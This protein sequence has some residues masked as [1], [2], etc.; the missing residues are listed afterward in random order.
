VIL[1]LASCAAVDSGED[2]T[3][4]G[5]PAAPPVGAGA[6]TMTIADTWAGDCEF[7]DPATYQ[8][9]QEWTFD[10]RGDVLVLYKDFWTL[11]SCTLDGAEFLCDDGSYQESRMQVTKE[12]EGSFA[13]GTT[14]EGALV[15]ELDCGGNGCDSLKD[16]YG[17]KLDFP[18]RA[19]APFS[20]TAK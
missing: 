1:L 13:T 3:E 4:T 17:K 19:E 11:V 9:A 18:C 2:A 14:V 20:G 15:V 6:F 8:P 5:V 10:P 7:D 12:I 16:L